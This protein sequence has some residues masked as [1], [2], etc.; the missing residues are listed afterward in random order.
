MNDEEEDEIVNEIDVFITS[1]A[2]DNLYFVQY[3]LRP[4]DNPYHSNPEASFQV[5]ES[6]KLSRN[7]SVIKLTVTLKVKPQML[8]MVYTNDDEADVQDQHKYNLTSTRQPMQT[9]YAIALL[10]G[11]TVNSK[12][13]NNLNDTDAK[14]TALDTNIL[15]LQSE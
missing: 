13:I 15:V 9:S 2:S 5:R 4:T 6:T 1:K 11:C 12:F 14:H 8:K 7:N 3:P 10:R